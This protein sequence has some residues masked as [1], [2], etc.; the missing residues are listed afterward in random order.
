MPERLISHAYIIR[1]INICLQLVYFTF[2]TIAGRVHVNVFVWFLA[3]LR[4]KGETI[5]AL[6]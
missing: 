4:K 3:N 1:R 6:L 2:L 5:E